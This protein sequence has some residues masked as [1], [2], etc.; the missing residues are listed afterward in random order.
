MLFKGRLKFR[1]YIK[2]KRACFGIKLYELCTSDGMTLDFLV[3]CGKG[4]FSND[5]PNSDMP[6]TGRIPSVLMSHHLGKGHIPCT[7]NYYT[8][9]TLAS[10]FLEKNTKTLILLVLSGLTDIIFQRISFQYLWKK[11]KQ[12]FIVKRKIRKSQ[13]KKYIRCWQSS[14]EQTKIKLTGNRKLSLCCQHAISPLWRE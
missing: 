13:T 14:T 1:Q 5:A 2:T 7:N 10:Y 11:Q 9:P 4:M 3:Y 6:A 12:L 8:S